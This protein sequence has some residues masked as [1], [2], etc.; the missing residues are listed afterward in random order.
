MNLNQTSLK[1]ATTPII[2]MASGK[3][4][5]GKTGMTLNLATL[6]A[7]QGLKVLVFDGDMGL[8]N[9]DVQLGLT[10]HKDLGHVISGQATLE[11][12]ISKS[13]RGF[14]VIPGRSG[15][16]QLP[17]LTA[18][19]Q[20]DILK[21]LRNVAGAFDVVLIDVAAGVGKEVLTFV[22]FADRTLL[23]TT[24]DPSSITDAYAVAKLLKVR[25][26]KETCEVLVNNAGTDSEGR[27]TYEKMKTAA[28]KFLGVDLP[29]VGIVPHDR[30]YATA[31]KMQKVAAQAFPN[32][33]AVKALTS[34]AKKI[35]PKREQ[36]AA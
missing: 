3:G 31:V 7:N 2:A 9:V 29:L 8:G 28:D 34:I 20:R 6:L 14:W 10:P 21:D 35:A 4:G 18:L 23:V 11:D 22:D 19:E 36:K 5:A 16:E 1:I 17:F 13:E 25:Y 15:H 32:C 33:D 26:N 24:P 27:M 30:Q 12:V